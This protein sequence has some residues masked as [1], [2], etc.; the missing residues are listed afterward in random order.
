MTLTE[1]MYHFWK[2]SQKNE[3]ASA[4]HRGV[5]NALKQVLNS[6]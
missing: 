4:T 5:G 1:T 2:T 6:D 3:H